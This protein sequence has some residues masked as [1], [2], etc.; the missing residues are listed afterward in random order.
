MQHFLKTTYI[1]I[2]CTALLFSC[3]KENYKN[4]GGVHDPHVNMSTYDY[5]RSQ[6]V[7]D[8]L[9]Y[10]IDKAGLKD[11]VN[12]DITFFAVTNYGV[13]DYVDIRQKRAAE[14]TGDENIPF[15]MDSIPVQEL[16]DSLRMYMVKGKINREQMNRT[17]QLYDCILGNIPNKKFMINLLRTYPYNDYV[18]Y[19][20]MVNYTLVIGGR[21]DQVADPSQIPQSEKDNPAV[22]Q[23]SGIITTTG[24]VHVL[25]GYHRLF[26]NTEVH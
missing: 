19:V 20:D 16:K 11:L 12:S 21:D 1:L 6:K 14:Q 22:C 9:V 18:S 10:L 4:D 26:F 2:C 24:V 25:N 3:K 5:L 8:S 13:N 7:F 23:T 17:G 15:S